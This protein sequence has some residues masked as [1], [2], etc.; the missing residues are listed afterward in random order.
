MALPSPIMKGKKHAHD[1][2][3][4]DAAIAL[5]ERVQPLKKLRAGLIFPGQRRKPLSDMSITKALRKAGR[6]ETVHGWRTSFRSWAGEAMLHIP[7]NVAELAIAHK[8][9]T[10]VEKAYNRADYHEMRRALFDGW[11]QFVAPW[12]S[13]APESV[14]PLRKAKVNRHSHTASQSQKGRIHTPKD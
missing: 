1:V 7:W 2:A 14:T 4:S 3:L 12:L 11:G 6:A 5:L 8:V 10:A 13:E 9:G